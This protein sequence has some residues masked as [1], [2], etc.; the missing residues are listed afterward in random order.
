MV[1]VELPY[2]SRNEP[3]PGEIEYNQ[4]KFKFFT[5][6]V[7]EGITQKGKIVYV[8]GFFEQSDLYHRLF[9]DL[10]EQGYEVF[11]FSQRGA[12][13]TSPN[14]LGLTN[15]FHV[16]DDLD[17]FI[18]Y[19]L[20]TPQDKIFLLGHSMGGGII[21]NYVIKGKYRKNIRGVLTSGP[22]VKLHPK[23][24]PNII[25]R[26]LSNYI[27]LLAPNLRIDSKLKFEYLTTN[28][29]WTEYIRKKTTKLLGS[30][31]QFYDMFERGEKL[32]DPSYNKDFQTPV[33]VL[34]GT[35]DNINDPKYSEK[36][37]NSIEFKDKE[38]VPVKGAK[39]SLFL[40]SEPIYR[41]I[42]LKKTVGF[43]NSH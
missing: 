26:S 36:F 40:E 2:K 4:A 8:H 17:F 29:D 5:W 19:N 28:P 15:E 1:E 42:V 34:H 31:R 24:Q 39:H 20:D 21:L 3:I 25:V 35:D 27:V 38:F 14:K 18:N 37:I 16:M 22:L 33:L 43:L 32:L 9:D 30:A 10:S 41:D 11:F 13:E 6:K 7:P 23:T 12:E